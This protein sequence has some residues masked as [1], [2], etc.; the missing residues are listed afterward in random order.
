MQKELFLKRFRL[1]RTLVVEK[2]EGS[3]FLPWYEAWGGYRERIAYADVSEGKCIGSWHLVLMAYDESAEKSGLLDQTIAKLQEVG[4]WAL[5]LFAPRM[6]TVQ[7]AQFALSHH[8]Y[9]LSAIPDKEE[10]A[11]RAIVAAMPPLLERLQEQSRCA[12]SL[13][14]LEMSPPFVVMNEKGEMVASNS[15]AIQ[16]F[17]AGNKETTALKVQVLLPPVS[18]SQEKPSG[19]VTEGDETLLVARSDTEKK[20]SLYTFVPMPKSIDPSHEKLLSRIEFIDMLKDRMAQRI[21]P[22]EKVSLLLVR[23]ENYTKIEESLGWLTA[24]AVIKEFA[25]TLKK[26][27]V[28]MESLG[29]WHRDFP[30]ALFVQ[31]SVDELRNAVTSFI[32]ELRLI[33]F[34][35][36]VK[37]SA[38]FLI[39]EIEKGELDALINL[40]EKCYKNDLSVTDT[41]GFVLHRTT[42]DRNVPDER[43]LLEQFFTNIMANRMPLK[44]LNIYKGLPI[45]TP[46]KILKMDG[47]KIVVT[48]EKLQK[49]VMEM[50][51]QVVF[52]SPHLPG[53]VAADVHMI[54]PVRPLAVLKNL[55]MLHSSINNRKHTRVTVPSRLPILLKVEKK[56]YTGYINDLSINSIAIHFNSGKFEENALKGRGS[57]LAFRLPWENDEGFI[58]LELT[59]EILF[60]KED[61]GV[62]KVVVI[63]APDDVN[64]TYLFDFI[65]KRQK[66]L[67]Q[68]LKSR[69]G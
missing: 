27:F 11:I 17:G 22:A 21:E 10:D 34:A 40:V 59:G 60:N 25:K 13:R 6:Q 64:E 5:L 38:E 57:A 12:Q 39:V 67:I 56:H 35:G 4:Y 61:D 31:R 33:E 47:E 8:A 1:L 69:I 14:Y 19:F 52:Q 53:D 32:G 46:T 41:D 7:A 9:A 16:L 62:H 36:K 68:E 20:E 26:H 55:K 2:G 30:V 48:A 37:V 66:A 45:S 54:D 50:E 58:P 51:R 23:L 42:S 63:L 65:Y 43:R 15:A 28:P 18:L 24:H 29:L 3:G 44:L 49:Y